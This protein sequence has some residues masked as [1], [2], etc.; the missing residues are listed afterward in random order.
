MLTVSSVVDEYCQL[1]V[2]VDPKTNEVK[3][4]LD[5]NLITTSSTYDVFGSDPFQPPKLPSFHNKNSFNYSGASVGTL[6]RELSGGPRLY[7]YFT[8]WIIGDGS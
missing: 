1:T 3:L 4:F 2:S 5:G 7:D 6:A 8:P